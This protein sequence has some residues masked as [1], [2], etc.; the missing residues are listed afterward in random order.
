VLVKTSWYYFCDMGGWEPSFLSSLLPPFLPL[1]QVIS[2]VKGL[3]A[4]RRAR[5]GRY[6]LIIIIII[7]I[8]TRGRY[9]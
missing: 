9:I 5:D 2:S 1:F 4:G 7:I 8:S 3:D 6:F